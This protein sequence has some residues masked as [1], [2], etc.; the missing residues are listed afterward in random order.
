VWA[1]ERLAHQAYVKKASHEHGAGLVVEK[2]ARAWCPPYAIDGVNSKFNGDGSFLVQLSD[3]SYR[4][5]NST[6]SVLGA[7]CLAEILLV[8]IK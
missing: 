5:I 6:L 3:S 7:H 1:L 8:C 4:L 2:T